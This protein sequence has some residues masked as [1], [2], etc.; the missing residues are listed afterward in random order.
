MV[1]ASSTSEPVDIAIIG[2]GA[3]GL[4]AGIFAARTRPGCS[5]ILLDGARTLGA[6]ILISGGGRCNVTNARV[7]PADFNGTRRFVE[8]VLQQFDEKAAV[9]WFNALGVLLKEEPSGKLFPVTNSARTV[10][11]ALLDHTKALG[12]RLFPQLRVKTLFPHEGSFHIETEHKT[13]SSRLVILAT[14]GQSLPKTGSD[15]HGWMMA[16]HVGHTVTPVYPALVPLILD[17]RFFHPGL[18]GIAHEVTIMTRIKNTLVDRRT[19]N[20]LW[21]HFGVS[22][23]IVLDMS[24]FW[25]IAHGEGQEVDVSL[26]LFPGQEFEGIDRW[27]SHAGTLSGRQTLAGLLSQHLPARVAKTLCTCIQEASSP[28]TGEPGPEETELGA[29]PLCEL[30]RASRR[31]V[32]QML[33]QLPLP[34]I[35]TRGWNFAEVTAGGI[36]LKEVNP[37]SM[38]SRR[39]PGLYLIGEMLDC[40]GR[41][42]GFNFQWAWSTGYIAGVHAARQLP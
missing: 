37:A 36:P 23:P 22:G 21:T 9:H 33:S 2:A 4:A 8:R 41:I 6:K 20:L 24:R 16:Q 1:S 38:A 34:V 25:S 19:G 5:I 42:G 14:G 13:F 18:S 31:A 3:A 39:V 35:G 17:P 40:D 32:T 26:N 28:T 30:R 27:L 29:T 10:L 7:T 15:G 11:Q 12:V